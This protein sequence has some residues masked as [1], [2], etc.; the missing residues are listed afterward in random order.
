MIILPAID[1]KDG[2]CV[3]LFKGDFSTVETVAE[4]PVET[5]K[6]FADCGAKW[7]HMVD[8]DGA[9]D[10][11][12]RNASVFL[13]VV[14]YSGLKVELGG[15]IRSME[16]IE[17]YL[18]NGISRIILGSAA[19]SDP[20]LVRLA[21]K[22]YGDKIAVGIDSKNRKVAVN[23][24]LDTSS[25]DFIELAK[26]VEQEGVGC[27]ICTDISKDG[28]LSGP[29]LAQL[30]ELN[31]AVSCNIIASG[32]IT[33]IDDIKN[34]SDLSL[35]GAICGKSVYKGTLDLAEAIKLSNNLM[36]DKCFN[37]SELIPAVIKQ[38]GTDEVLMLA[39][40]NCES[41]RLT[42]ETGYTWF[43]SR[44]RNKLWNKG[45][46]SGNKQKV[47]NIKADCDFDTLLID[48]EQTGP[49]CHTGRHNCFFNDF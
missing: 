30:E 32:G 27:I 43:F 49:A 34:L 9:K 47:V 23:G 48:V 6:Q 4:N 39:Y 5:A 21:C 36:I 7:I 10:A 24:W 13:D 40:M 41:L 35:Y 17:Y 28:T 33:N 31:N 46:T 3:R 29:N 2:N 42:I 18:E 16:T 45:E 12:P 14:K 1:I 26:R 19:L 15:G 44:S 38:S 22:T 37:K 25:M 8:L 20:Q 11:K